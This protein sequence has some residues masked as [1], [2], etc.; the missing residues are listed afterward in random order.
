[1]IEKKTMKYKS[2]LVTRYGDPEVLQVVEND[3]R[4]PANGEVRI[5]VLAAA[6]SRPDVTVRQG[7]ALY[8]GTPLEQKL[9][10]T[11]GYAVVGDIDA[12][13]EGAPKSLIGKRVGVLTVTGGYTE[14]LYWKSDRLIP[15]PIDL[16][17]AEA[18]PLIL[19][20]IVAYQVM[21]RSAKIKA[22]G[23]VLIIG[24]SGGIGTA[25]LQLGQL[26]GLKMYAI[27]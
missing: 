24:A 6:V 4:L 8:S 23:K 5:Q 10:F 1:V 27:A 22:G 7:K 14:V 17:P 15:V 2:I 26:A 21:H 12:V 9:P 3:M 25:L 18:V 16:D 13:G 19:N 11:P 20:Y